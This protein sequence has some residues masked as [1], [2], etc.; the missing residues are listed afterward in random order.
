[1]GCV[2]ICRGLMTYGVCRYMRRI[3]EC[4]L[5]RYVRGINEM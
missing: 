1:M 4:R 2:G 5:C 3:N